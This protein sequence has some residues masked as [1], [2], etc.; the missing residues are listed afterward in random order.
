MRTVASIGIMIAASYFMP[1]L[2]MGVMATRVAVAVVTAAGIYAISALFPVKS[3]SGAISS[4]DLNIGTA[5]LGNPI[6]VIFGLAKI[7]A[8]CMDYDIS[9]LRTEDIKV[10]SGKGGGSQV[11]GQKYFLSY[12]QILAM[13]EI[14]MIKQIWTSPGA[15]GLLEN[16][17][18]NSGT[19]FTEFELSHG[20][21]L[22]GTVRFYWG[23][24]DQTRVAQ[25]DPY[26]PKGYNLRNFC[27][28]LMGTQDPTT[29][30][31]GYCLGTSKTISSYAWL[32]QRLPKNCGNIYTRGSY[33]QNHLHYESANPSAVMYEALTNGVWG[34]GINANLIDIASFERASYYYASNNF[35]LNFALDDF[36][37][38]KELISALQVHVKCNLLQENG[39]LKFANLMYQF[40]DLSYAPVISEDE[41]VNFEF[42]TATYST[43]KTRV[44]ADFT[45]PAQN[46]KNSSVDERNDALEEMLA[47]SSTHKVNLSMFIDVETVRT[48][49]QRFLREIGTQPAVAKVTVNRSKAKLQFGDLVCL[50]WSAYA[51]SGK[52]ILI[53][54]R[55]ASKKLSGSDA[56]TIDLELIEALEYPRQVVDFN[57]AIPS[58][59]GNPAWGKSAPVVKNAD[60]SG[61]SGTPEKF[62]PAEIFEVPA[63]LAQKIDAG[64]DFVYILGQKQQFATSVDYWFS[65]NGTDY[66]QLD[67]TN[68][69]T[70][71]GTL[72]SD[73]T[74]LNYFDRTSEIEIVISNS[75]YGTILTSEYNKVIDNSE[76]LQTLISK[77][78][79]YLVIENEIM[80]VGSLTQ[81]SGDRYIAKNLV[82][83]LFGT[84]IKTHS[85]G[86]TC[87]F[88]TSWVKPVIASSVPNGQ[89][90]YWRGYPVGLNGVELVADDIFLKNA[91]VG[92][93][94]FGLSTAPLC[95]EISEITNVGLNYTIKLR[96]RLVTAG[97]GINSLESSLYSKTSN[98]DQ[99]FILE[100]FNDTTK[101]STTVLN[102][103]FDIN[104]GLATATITLNSST[105][106]YK[107]YSQRN[108]KN[109]LEV[110]D[111]YI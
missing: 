65:V 74:K 8:N 69:Q 55:V 60:W 1:F 82:R 91:N 63:I 73:I 37:S 56:E 45:D 111:I 44:C 12:E 83:G 105:N 57:T 34:L 80:A 89:K 19:D 3:N 25:G 24:A 108:G 90:I 53:A 27:W 14:D 32:V 81:I 21:G 102:S 76:D 7:S 107:I 96:P 98:I 41:C 109:S 64:N 86:E 71:A 50:K 11:A 103:T 88:V 59:A 39:K 40:T 95:P 99:S 97:A 35:G 87:W 61:G 46:Y 13:G 110:K 67:N 68:S 94:K 79:D 15:E 70:F 62:Y 92:D 93:N 85:V 36:T 18:I 20:D 23:S 10:S 84:E 104:S 52:T 9:N 78:T 26:Q 66:A 54:M 31:G 77:N 75:T 38:I 106:N 48:V 47:T 6:P 58:V 51:E 16:P 43:S 29:L 2:G 17:I 72:N 28:M 42:Q 101:L 4:Q 33:D 22:G 100:E 49:A 30:A 5:T